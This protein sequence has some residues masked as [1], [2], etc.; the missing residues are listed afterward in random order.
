MLL[1]GGVQADAGLVS[2]GG[3]PLGS[4]HCRESAKHAWQTPGRHDQY[5][6]HHDLAPRDLGRRGRLRSAP[7]Q[8]Q[9]RAGPRRPGRPRTTPRAS[10]A[11]ASPDWTVARV[12]EQAGKVFCLVEAPDADTAVRVHREPGSHL[13]TATGAHCL[14]EWGCRLSGP[15]LFMQNTTVGSPSGPAATSPP[16]P[17]SGARSA[18]AAGPPRCRSPGP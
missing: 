13:P 18:A 4:Q 10:A 15:N 12:D 7:P 11:T 6:V 16:T 9:G 17:T 1:G 2:R 3:D 5:T 14:P 8:R